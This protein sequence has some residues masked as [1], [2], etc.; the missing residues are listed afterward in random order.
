LIGVLSPAYPPDSMTGL[1]GAR[2]SLEL[3]LAHGT[4]VG[5]R[6]EVIEPLGTDHLGV[7][8]SAKD[9]K[10]GRPI[11]LRLLR[12]DLAEGDV[13]QRIR[14]EARTA[15][16]LTHRS[17]VTTYGV[18]TAPNGAMFVA[19][20]AVEGTQLSELLASKR[21]KSERM[22]L[23]GAYN[24]IAHVCKALAAVEA[25]T[26]HG[27]LR[28]SVVWVSNSGRV[29][30]GD[31]GISK[32][33]VSAHTATVLGPD[34]QPFLAPEVKGGRIPDARSDIFGIG[35]ILYQLLTGRTPAEG[36]IPPSQAHPDATPELDRVLLRCLA[37]KPEGRFASP[38]E[39]RTALLPLVDLAPDVTM[40][41]D[42]GV[43]VEIEGDAPRTP[44]P[45]PRPGPKLVP[46]AAPAMVETRRAPAP[47]I[48]PAP[49][50]R[51]AQAGPLDLGAVLA[52]VTQNDAPRWMVT[53]DGLDHGPF[54]ARELVTTIANGEA[55][56]AHVLLNMDTG[57]RIALGTHADFGEFVAQREQDEEQK[58]YKKS[59]EHAVASETKSSRTKLVAAG[60]ILLMVIA[61]LGVFF[62]TRQAGEQQAV[63]E[64]EVGNLFD[65]GQIQASA[66][67]DILPDRPTHAGGHHGGGHAPGTPRPQ[68]E[69][70]GGSA[71]G[72]EE[73]MNRA[74][75]MG[76]ITQATD[77]SRL[78]GPEVAG[79][80]N[81]HIGRI[82]A[83]CVPAEQARGGTLGRVQI[84]IAIAGSGSV[85]GASARQGSGAFQACIGRA[86]SSV[87]FPS[88]GAPRMG[89]RYSFSAN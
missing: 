76:D 66:S 31:F 25:Q 49:E 12:T 86:V 39:V 27:T 67:G 19:T 63:T 68:G 2:L 20:E 10:T 24:V 64:R 11:T 58:A 88:F 22:S 69:T 77:Q 79:I 75:D 83:A 17:I 78:T 50:P 40:S 35:G 1:D 34:E 29:K 57:E 82:Y 36:F 59:V 73:A 61:G 4:V 45:S 72:Y 52:R 28:P 30:V 14:A 5:G 41:E 23:R 8:L 48:A 70:G 7:L 84:D 33:L 9:Q 71:G 53:M 21:Q 55:R 87:R 32:V 51:V 44:A 81:R 43:D 47:V 6:F 74:V 26:C 60:A 80:M 3:V 15:A 38:D 46:V 62:Y 85:L 37:S 16:T 42:F 54:T 13:A 89:A 65:I 56:R 18:G